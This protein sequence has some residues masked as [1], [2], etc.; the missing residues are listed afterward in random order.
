MRRP[1]D[2]E[3]TLRLLLHQLRLLKVPDAVSG[4]RAFRLLFWQP[5]RPALQVRPC[6]CVPL[7]RHQCMAS[8]RP[9]NAPAPLLCSAAA[10]K[11][12]LVAAGKA[13]L[14]LM[15]QGRRL[16]LKARALS[17]AQVGRAGPRVGWRAH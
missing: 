6:A 11:D 13:H 7:C 2:A 14:E 10:E 16:Y 8:Q 3:N 5:Q 9:T 4:E 17:L 1:G 15:E 12:L